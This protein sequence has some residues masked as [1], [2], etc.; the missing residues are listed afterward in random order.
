MA[1]SYQRVN[2]RCIMDNDFAKIFKNLK[3]PN[4]M[5]I[6]MGTVIKVSPFKISIHDKIIVE[7]ENLVISKHLLKDYEREF[8]IDGN[9]K[10]QYNTELAQAGVTGQAT[11]NPLGH[12]HEIK[13]N[14]VSFTG[15]GK[16]KWTDSLKEGDIVIVS[17]SADEQTYFIHD[18]GE[19]QG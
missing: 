3:N 2:L 17:V 7:A 19:V 16:I 11:E 13:L 5:G 4:L 1:Y 18:I 9:M 6:V 15:K 8:E 14:N 10:L 12:K